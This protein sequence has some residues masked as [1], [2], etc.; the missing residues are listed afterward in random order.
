MAARGVKDFSVLLLGVHSRESPLTSGK[1][2]GLL[3]A[4]QLPQCSDKHCI[5]SGLDVALQPVQH[6]MYRED[7]VFLFFLFLYSKASAVPGC[8]TEVLNSSLQCSGAQTKRR[9]A[10]P[11]AGG[12]C[13]TLALPMKYGENPFILNVCVLLIKE[14]NLWQCYL[15]ERLTASTTCTT[16]QA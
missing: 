13:L 6:N 1:L 11:S 2:Q 12:S 14:R 8:S 15:V 7:D 10:P 4:N 9:A 5:A 16:A 3:L